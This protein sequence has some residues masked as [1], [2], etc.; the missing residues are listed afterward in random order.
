MPGSCGSY[1]KMSSN[2]KSSTI[3]DY[4]VVGGTAGFTDIRTGEVRDMVEM[5]VLGFTFCRVLAGGRPYGP[6]K[7]FFDWTTVT[8]T[9]SPRYFYLGEATHSAL[10]A[11][12]IVTR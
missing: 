12:G 1:Y 8:M 6:D 9:A 3:G 2:N 11:F 4:V 10:E 5:L 7:A